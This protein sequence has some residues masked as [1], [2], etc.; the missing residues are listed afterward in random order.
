MESIV[1]YIN[2]VL[3][4]K[5]LPPIHRVGDE[6]IMRVLMRQPQT[7]GHRQ[8]PDCPEPVRPAN[9]GVERTK[10]TKAF[11]LL[12]S[13]KPQIQAMGAQAVT[14]ILGGRTTGDHVGP[15][16]VFVEAV[17]EAVQ[18]EDEMIL[19]SLLEMLEEEYKEGAARKKAKTDVGPK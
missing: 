2:F 17:K 4:R 19:D 18:D 14:T 3:C 13:P 9:K 6:C 5:S 8:T 11:E 15:V 1:S 16:V 7:P 10:A 12:K